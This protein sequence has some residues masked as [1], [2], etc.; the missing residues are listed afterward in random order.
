L[1]AAAGV[2]AFLVGVITAGGL[3]SPPEASDPRGDVGCTDPPCGPE[4]LPPLEALPLALP[5]LLVAAAATLAV[6]LAALAAVRGPRPRLPRTGAGLLLAAGA[7]LVFVGAEIVPHVASPCWAGEIEG[8][9][10][11]TERF[12]IDYTDRL[13]LLAHA[14]VGWVPLTIAMWWLARR[15]LL[16]RQRPT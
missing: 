13:H 10:V 14:L 4:S 11:S 7:L 5:I 9:C 12:G 6:G 2:T 1:V 8:V 15:H 3:W 16:D